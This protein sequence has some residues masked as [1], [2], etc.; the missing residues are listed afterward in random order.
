MPFRFLVDN[1]LWFEFRDYLHNPLHLMSFA[2]L[3]IPIVAMGI[4]DDKIF[5][6]LPFVLSFYKSLMY[7]R[8]NH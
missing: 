5:C 6:E 4:Y 2:L 3:R 7:E 8:M 1:S